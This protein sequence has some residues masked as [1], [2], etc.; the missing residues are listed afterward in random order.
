MGRV[1]AP[2][3]FVIPT[4]NEEEAIRPTLETVPRKALEDAGHSVEVLVV[5]G[6][7]TDETRSLAKA[8]GARVIVEPRPGYGRAYKTGFQEAN[9]EIIV[10]GDADATYPFEVTPRLLEYLEEGADFVTTNRFAEMEPDAM[11][12]KHQFGNWVLSTGC[13]VLFATGFRDSQSGMWVFKR[14]ILDELT[15]TDDGMPFSEEIK[16]EAYRHPDVNAIEVDIPY[17]ERIGTVKL[18]SWQDGVRNFTFLFKKRLGL[19]D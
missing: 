7:S 12:P 16:I 15:L 10:T 4:L 5:D 19:A 13:R 1:G 11:S 17:R 18:D 9:G 14:E 2:I 6:D 3:T 8:S